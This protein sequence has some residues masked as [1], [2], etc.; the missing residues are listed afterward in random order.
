VH[1]AGLALG[2]TIKT[3]GSQDAFRAVDANARAMTA[4]N[5]VKG[6]TP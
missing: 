6:K 4:Y 3:I 2:T 1:E 5:W